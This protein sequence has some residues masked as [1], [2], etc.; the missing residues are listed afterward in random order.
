MRNSLRRFSPGTAEKLKSYVYAYYDPASPDYPF[1][2]GRGVNDRAFDHLKEAQGGKKSDKAE[3]IR[4]IWGSGHDVEIQIIRHGLDPEQARHVEAALISVY[5]DALNEIEGDFVQQ[6]LIH[7]NEADS[8]LAA[9]KSR[10]EFP[11][12]VINIR[13]NWSWVYQARIQDKDETEYKRRLKAST[14]SCWRV[15][16]ANHPDVHH[17]ISYANGLIRQVYRIERWRKADIGA[18]GEVVE[19][20]KRKLFEGEPDPEY[21]C[22][23]GCALVDDQKPPSGSQNPIRYL[24]S[25]Q[26]EIAARPLES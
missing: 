4:Q 12:V 10:I 8:T 9:E 11:A 14:S 3:R 17:A 1:Y 20:P 5:P 6:G 22:L 7:A 15:Q 16:P 2:I 23:V 24:N 25:P 19:D 13:R 18:R 26:R 21:S